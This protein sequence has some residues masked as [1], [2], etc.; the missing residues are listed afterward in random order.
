MK[1]ALLKEHQ[2]DSYQVGHHMGYNKHKLD[3]Q[4]IGIV[5]RDSRWFQ[6]RVREAIQIRSR[7]PTLNCDRGRHNLPSVY[8]TI[9]RSRDT[10]MTAAV[11][12][13]QNQS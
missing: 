3:S 4:N 2:K 9:V 5:D 7:S 1:H 6:R 8:D 11:S 10:R 12:R 13:D